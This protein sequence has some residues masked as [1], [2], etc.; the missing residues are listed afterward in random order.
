VIFFKYDAKTM[1]EHGK[2]RPKKDRLCFPNQENYSIQTIP[3]WF[4]L[5]FTLNF[6]EPNHYNLK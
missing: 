5:K 1:A 4:Y 3:D 2:A 6:P